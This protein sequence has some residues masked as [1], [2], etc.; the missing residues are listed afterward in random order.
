MF[1]YIVM[2]S[3]DDEG[4]SIIRVFSDLELSNEYARRELNDCWRVQDGYKYVTTVD[5]NGC[6]CYRVDNDVNYYVEK[7]GLLDKI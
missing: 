1:V 4:E 7:H 3:V 2:R 5:K 6:V